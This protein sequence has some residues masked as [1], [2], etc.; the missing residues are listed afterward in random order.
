MDVFFKKF[1][2][3]EEIHMK[4]INWANNEDVESLA[5][6]GFINIYVKNKDDKKIV[7]NAVY[8]STGFLNHCGVFIEAQNGGFKIKKTRKSKRRGSKK[9]R[10]TK[11]RRR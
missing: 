1:G 7:Q 11:R 6:D 8:T 10:T 5:K 3:N 4:V 9:R 2:S